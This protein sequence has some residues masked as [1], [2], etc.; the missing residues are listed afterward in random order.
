MDR[1]AILQVL[2]DRFPD[3]GLRADEKNLQ[4][5]VVDAPRLVEVATFLKQEPTLDFDYQMVVTAADW[6]EHVDVIHYFMS[7]QHQHTIALKVQLPD[8]K[9]EMDSLVPLWASS[10]WHEREVYDLFGVTFNGH[11]DLRRILMPCDWEGYPLRKN[12]THPNLVPLPENNNPATL[13]GMGHHKI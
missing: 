2:A 9:L 11:P 7:Y 5:I 1:K 4:A 13:T 10:N 8:G 3:A 6:V 12:F